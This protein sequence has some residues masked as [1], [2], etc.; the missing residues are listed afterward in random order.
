MLSR[1]MVIFSLISL[2]LVTK[3]LRHFVQAV[4]RTKKP[5]AAL[6]RNSGG[7]AF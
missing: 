6:S 2:P 4:F 1:Y 5:K 7:T 3:T